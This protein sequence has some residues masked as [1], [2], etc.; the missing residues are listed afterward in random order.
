MVIKLSAAESRGHSG[1]LLIENGLFL[2]VLCGGL[3]SAHRSK[4]FTSSY[5]SARLVNDV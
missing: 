5:A 2:R 4:S 1:S 3:V